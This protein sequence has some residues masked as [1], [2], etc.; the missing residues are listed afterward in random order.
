VYFSR[1]F[2]IIFERYRKRRTSCAERHTKR[3]IYRERGYWERYRL[4]YT[5]KNISGEIYIKIYRERGSWERYRLKY[6]EEEE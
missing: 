6:T 4:K 3:K 1:P 5:E 2:Y